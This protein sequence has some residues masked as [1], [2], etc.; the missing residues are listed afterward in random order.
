MLTKLKSY[1]EGIETTP[2]SWL[3]GMSG[4]LMVRF[5]IE[6]FSSPTSSGFLGSDASTLIHYY[7]FFLTVAVVFMIFIKLV[8]PSWKKIAPQFVSLAFIVVL[9]APIIDWVVSGGK[10]L[11]MTYLFNSPKEM[12]FS[13]LTFFG[14][15]FSTGITFG[16]RIEMAV[17]LLFVGAIV[18]STKRSIFKSIISVF[19]IYVLIFVFLSLPGVIN[20]LGG[21]TLDGNYF[22]DP[23]FFI[24]KSIEGSATISNNIHSSLR[25]YSVVRMFEVAF[26]FL[27]GKILFIILVVSVLLW[28]YLNFKEKLKSVIIN[29]RPERVAHYLLMIFFGLFTAHSMF[30]G[31]KLNWNDWLSVLMLCFAF[32]F[33]WMFAV[34][35]NDVA[36]EDIDKVSNSGRPLITNLLSKED[37]KQA[38]TLFLVASLL[39]AFL[40]GYSAFFF[41]LAFTALYYIYSAPPTRFKTVP[42][43]SSFLIGLCCLTAVMAGFFLLSP[44]KYASAF[45][46]KIALAVVIIFSLLTSVRDMKD[47]EG[48][49]KAGIK[50]TPIV[51]GDVWGPRVVG[52]FAGLS[53]ILVPIFSGVYLIFITAIPAA[54]TSYYF[55]NRKP[56]VEKPIFL[57]YFAFILT[58][59]I[60]L[61]L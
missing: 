25:Y 10:G 9:V 43:F 33:S 31:V 16:L 26:N 12:I 44:I 2:T 28:F 58:S 48:D 56:Y 1:L 14:S 27:M 41:V 32:Y 8:L 22:K 60:L 5:F 38:A 34:C 46:P 29:S 6:A 17:I 24:Q 3:L 19:Y 37:M 45:P 54:I 13:F 20:L 51:F 4:I 23:L 53:Y 30:G 57:I 55:V 36:D 47:I 7:L 50:T 61:S 42:F 59:L 11:T 39:S 52:I 15:D 18:Y 35:V 21:H 49:K 40:A